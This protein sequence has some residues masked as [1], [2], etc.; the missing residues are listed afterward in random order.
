MKEVYEDVKIRVVVFDAE[1]V[2]TSS[3]TPNMHDPNC[4]SEVPGVCTAV[5]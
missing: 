5:N 3:C 2:I 1:D 4:G